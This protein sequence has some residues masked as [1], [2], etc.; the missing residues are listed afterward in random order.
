MKTVGDDPPFGASPKSTPSTPRKSPYNHSPYTSITGAGTKDRKIQSE[1]PSQPI[2]E[3]ERYYRKVL[4]V[5]TRRGSL[6]GLRIQQKGDIVFIQRMSAHHTMNLS[7]P[8][9]WDIMRK[10]YM[11][12]ALSEDDVDVLATLMI[13]NFGGYSQESSPILEELNWWR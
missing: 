7:L 12:F 1:S 10:V 3:A 13:D 8:F 6:S 2:S 4:L 11:L 5:S 9:T